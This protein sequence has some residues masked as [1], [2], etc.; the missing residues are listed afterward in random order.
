MFFF[1]FLEV[2][3]ILTLLTRSFRVTSSP[4]V[5]RNLRRWCIPSNNPFEL[6]YS[7]YLHIITQNLFSVRNKNQSR[8][9]A[10]LSRSSIP[11][12]K[13]VA[14]NFSARIGI[15]K[16]GCVFVH[17]LCA[18]Q[19][20]AIRNRQCRNSIS[21]VSHSLVAFYSTAESKELQMMNISIEKERLTC[22]SASSIKGEKV[23]WLRIR[24]CRKL[25]DATPT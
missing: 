15:P 21:A 3:G 11:I 6:C 2:Q 22:I 25:L 23:S 4:H 1:F 5:Q 18:K 20:T 14:S 17:A 24:P 13:T 9:P 8:S 12:L 16:S 7:K 19:Q 10:P